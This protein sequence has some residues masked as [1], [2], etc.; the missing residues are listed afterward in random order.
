MKTYN[1]LPFFSSSVETCYQK[2]DANQTYKYTWAEQTFDERKNKNKDLEYITYK[3]NNC[4]HRCDDFKNQHEGKHI[5][6]AGDSFTFGE[7]LGYQENWSGKLYNKIKNRYDC[8]GYYTLGFQ[9][10]VISHIIHNIFRYCESFGDPEFIF[11]FFPDAV[12]KISLG[13]EGRFEINYKFN[14]IESAE[15]L[16]RAYHNIYF[17]EKYCNIK[18]IKLI[19]SSW[20]SGDSVFYNKL[21]LKNF[22]Y[23]KEEDILISANNNNEKNHPLYK[24]AR[25]S[26]HPGLKYSDGLSNIFYKKFEEIV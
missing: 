4:G 5:L 21:P 14:D 15:G 22:I 19:W 20:H 11:C 17:L 24:I 9:N 16:S 13:N 2:F 7:G 8:D 10:G 3:L 12:R 18:N 23:I 1:D 6:F 26:A 25:D